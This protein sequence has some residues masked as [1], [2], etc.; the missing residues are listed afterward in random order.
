MSSELL[1][2]FL[3]LA[4]WAR[5]LSASLL[6]KPRFRTVG[7]AIDEVEQDAET[8]KLDGSLIPLEG[9]RASLF[10]SRRFSAFS[11]VPMSGCYCDWPALQALKPEHC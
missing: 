5:S 7:S 6:S 10:V 1:A 9:G 2:W 4:L 8:F 11:G 3:M